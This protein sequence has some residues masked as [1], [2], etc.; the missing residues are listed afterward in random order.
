ML[1]EV[2][3]LTSGKEQQKAVDRMKAN[4][5]DRSKECV[6]IYSSLIDM[7]KKLRRNKAKIENWKF[8]NPS[9]CLH[10][11]R[12]LYMRKKLRRNKVKDKALFVTDYPSDLYH[13]KQEGMYVAAWLHGQNGQEDLSGAAYAVMDIEEIDWEALERIYLRLAGKPWTVMETGRC[14]VRE[15]TVEDVEAFYRIYAEPSITYYMEDLFPEIEEEREYTRNYIEKIY[16]F[17]GYGLWSIVCKENQEVIGRAGLS[18][19]EGFDTP[20]LGFVIGVPYQRKG[21]AY[22]V[23]KAIIAYGEEE[24]GFEKIQA[25]V[26]EGNEASACLCRKLGFWK[27]DRV[28]DKGVW[29]ERYV[30]RADACFFDDLSGSRDVE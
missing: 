22:E 19:R 16:G 29:Y 5:G 17:Y 13:L 26:R 28:E 8:S 9:L 24:L 14:M 4:M 12:K 2:I 1:K 21:Y 10:S 25:L 3:F 18:W 20:E 6:K 15:M 30:K 27:E 11:I 23:C 7:R